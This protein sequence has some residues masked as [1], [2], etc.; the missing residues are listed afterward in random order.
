MGN[1]TFRYVEDL[2]HLSHIQAQKYAQQV[3]ADYLQI[4]DN[5]YLP[6]K[7][8]VYQKLKVFTFDYDQIFYV[9]SDAVIMDTIPDVFE[10]F[11]E[12]DFSATHEVNWYGDSAYYKTFRQRYNKTLGAPTTYYPFNSGVML[13]NRKFIER[14]KNKWQQYIDTFDVKGAQDQGI[15]NRLVIDEQLDYNIMPMDYGTL[16]RKGKYIIHLGGHKKNNFNLEK[17]CKLNNLTYPK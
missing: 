9:D 5:S 4:T 1:K 13:F 8:A 16:C 6:N 17:F 11:G 12:Y 15:F 3:N 2:Y 10:L 14:N 7:H